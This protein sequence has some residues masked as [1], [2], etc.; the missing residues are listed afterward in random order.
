[1]NDRAKIE[2]PEIKDRLKEE[3][4]KYLLVSLYLTVCFST[5]I[6]YRSSVTGAQDSDFLN[7]GAAVIKALVLGKF[8]LIGAAMKTG[9]R[10]SGPTLTHRIF[11]KSVSFLLLLIVFTILEEIVVG[12]FHSQGVIESVMEYWHKPWLEK[13][14]PDLVMLMILIPMVAASEMHRS[15]GSEHMKKIF[16]GRDSD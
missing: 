7:F 16:L 4:I 5:L 15:L 8:I 9:E 3:L 10:V 12:L 2:T 6:L 11:I 1:M 14:A 13:L